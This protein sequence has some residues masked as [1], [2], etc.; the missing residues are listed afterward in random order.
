MR[1]N[2]AKIPSGIPIKVAKNKAKDRFDVPTVDPDD[3][4]HDD[5]RD[6]HNQMHVRK[7][8]NEA[9]GPYASGPVKVYTPAEIEAM[10][11]ERGTLP[12]EKTEEPPKKKTPSRKKETGLRKKP[13]SLRRI[14]GSHKYHSYIGNVSG[15]AEKSLS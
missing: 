14:I 12:G 1:F 7:T 15:Y 10:N 5:L 8:Y 2:A 9:V 6:V 11:R 13:G 4:D 3:M